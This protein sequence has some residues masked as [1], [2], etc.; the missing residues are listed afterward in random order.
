MRIQLSR[1]EALPVRGGARRTVRAHAGRVW[2]TEEKAM[3]DVVLQAGESFRL[4]RP[5]LAVLEAFQDAW[6]SI[7]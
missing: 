1:G 3:H 4:A 5:G 7:E 6:I 2:I